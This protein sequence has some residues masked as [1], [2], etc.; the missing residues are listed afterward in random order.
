LAE[1]EN[2][3]IIDVANGTLPKGIVPLENHFNRDD[4][5]KGKPSKKINDE[6]IE[7]NIGTEESSKLVKFGKGTM[8]DERE[9]LISLIR[10]FKDVFSWYYKYIKAFREEL[11]QHAIP[12]IDG[13]KPFRKNLKEMNP[14][15]STQVQKE[16]KNMVEAGIIKPIRYSS[17]VSNRV[18]VRKKSGEIRICVEFR[19][20]NQA[21]PKDNY[22]LPNMEYLF[23]RVMG[24]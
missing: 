17:W 5:Y 9:K 6:I 19:N 4:M 12:L 18:I 20:L 2:I 10:E 16:L 24:A 14:K 23:Q 8:T 13:T 1:R 7:F 3:E 22:P 21:S 11:M 15:V